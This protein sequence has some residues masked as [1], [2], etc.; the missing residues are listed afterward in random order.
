M[1][2]ELPEGRVGYPRMLLSSG[3]RG[4]FV[5]LHTKQLNEE[6]LSWSGPPLLVRLATPFIIA[7]TARTIEVHDQALL[8]HVQT[9]PL[10]PG[11]GRWICTAASAMPP[12]LHDLVYLSQGD[13]VKLLKIAPVEAQVEALV[14]AGKYEEALAI[15]DL[16]SAQALKGGIDVASIHES[17]AV[18]LHTRGD[19]ETSIAHFILAET[20][21]A[22]VCVLFPPL[23][24]QKLP[25][26][27]STLGRE[28]MAAAAQSLSASSLHRAAAALTR[29]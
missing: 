16:C 8:T 1:A 23:I 27:P 21:P 13:N 4:V 15:C 12:A 19:Y 18:L 7:L 2:L 26:P 17:Y 22:Q 29:F 9:L 25:M 6:R 10:G 20:P 11:D 3:A 14:D 28:P 24:P 5:N